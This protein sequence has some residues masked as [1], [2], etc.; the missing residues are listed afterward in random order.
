MIKITI[1]EDNARKY[2]TY[3]DIIL[4]PIDN[5]KIPN[6]DGIVRE[7]ANNGNLVFE[8]SYKNNKLEG[9][10]KEYGDKRGDLIRETDYINGKENGISK[11]YWWGKL[12]EETPYVNGKKH[13]VSKYRL[14]AP[15]PD[16][17]ILYN[18]EYI[19]KNGEF[20][21]GH[22]YYPS[23]KTEKLVMKECV[24]GNQTYSEIVTEANFNRTAFRVY[25]NSEGEK[26]ANEI[27]NSYNEFEDMDINK[28][29]DGNG[30]IRDYKYNNLENASK[31]YEENGKLMQEVNYINGKMVKR[32]NYSL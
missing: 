8:C 29:S 17:T 3:H 24:K 22:R 14:M 32:M 4:Y 12:Q 5:W 6:G 9:V 2:Y 19:Y 23:G 18:D 15:R 30:T 21:E 20:I 28:L 27:I 25:Y 13:G 26:V 31:W 10:G 16:F 1:D 7:F 11:V